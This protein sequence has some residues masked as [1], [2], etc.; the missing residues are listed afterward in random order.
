FVTGGLGPTSDDLTCEVVAQSLGLKL[1][2]NAKLLVV[3]EQRF[4]TR[5]FKWTE[6]VA[7]QAD[8][9]SGAHVLAND[10]GSAPGFYLRANINPQIQSPHIFVLPGPPRELRPMFR[11]R[12]MSILSAIVADASPTERRLYKIAGMAES[13]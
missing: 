13:L 10:N 9:P 3:L 2:R 12:A 5:G 8:V 1:E 11:D 7:R 4:K 6:R